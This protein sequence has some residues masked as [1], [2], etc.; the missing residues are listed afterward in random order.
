[1]IKM[2]WIQLFPYLLVDIAV[3]ISS[4]DS[5]GSTRPNR[6]EFEASSGWVISWFNLT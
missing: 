5:K 6:P 1:M 3:S 2:W 4:L